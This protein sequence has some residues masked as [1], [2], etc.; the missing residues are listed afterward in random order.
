MQIS[1]ALDQP[2]FGKVNGATKKV[3]DTIKSSADDRI[4]LYVPCSNCCRN[5]LQN[6]KT[7]L[8]FKQIIPKMV[9][10]RSSIHETCRF[11]FFSRDSLHC[12]SISF[13]L[14]LFQKRLL[15]NLFIEEL[16]QRHLLIGV[17]CV[18]RAMVL[19]AL[20]YTILQ[21][22]RQATLGIKG[23]S[24][25]YRPQRLPNWSTLLQK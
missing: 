17:Q 1:V 14:P 9:L 10:L 18:Q 6:T 20:R 19:N 23:S 16:G 13:G 4:Y 15:K 8:H 3:L 7:N 25:G 5:S 2:G 11:L 12:S 21:V 24:H 22:G